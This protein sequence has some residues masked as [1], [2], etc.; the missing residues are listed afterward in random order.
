MRND[1]MKRNP[2]QRKFS[3]MVLNAALFCGATF[4]G[5]AAAVAQTATPLPKAM[6]EAAS[7]QSPSLMS[8]DRYL[9]PQDLAAVGYVEQEY[10]ISGTANVYDWD[11]N[12]KLAVK[13]ANAPYGSR[14]RVRRPKDPAKFSGTVVVELPNAA[15]RFDWDMMWGYLSDE[16]IARGDGWV[17]ITPPPATP[18]LKVF[19]PIRYKDVSFANPAPGDCPT[20]AAAPPIEEGLRWDMYSQVGAPIK[21]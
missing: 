4:F 9:R 11:A 20:G 10:L 6:L 21:N 14:I 17:A 16:I 1:G 13:T 2:T 15:R 8:A 5:P 19:D 12:G 3:S 18:G 7:P